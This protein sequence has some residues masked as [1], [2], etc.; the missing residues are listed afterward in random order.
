MKEDFV[1][2]ENTFLPSDFDSVTKVE[3]IIDFV[4]KIVNV[5]EDHYGNIL[6]AV[7][8]AVNNAI[9]HG[10]KLNAAVPFNI[11]AAHS[12]SAFCFTICDKGDGFN[13]DELP[14]PTNPE[15]IIKDNG[16]GVFL[17][18]SLSDNVK[19]DD[20]GRSVTVYFNK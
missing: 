6:I 12:Y 20:G 19:F 10:N 9:I 17:M 14:D 4:C 1:I 7:T 18:K 15:N 11:S 8:E 3:S 16:R 13:Y 5:S 2:L